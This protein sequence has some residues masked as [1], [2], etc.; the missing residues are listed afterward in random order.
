M[1]LPLPGTK[2][3]LR[4]LRNR[5][6]ERYRELAEMRQELAEVRQ[7]LAKERKKKLLMLAM[8]ALCLIYLVI[9]GTPHC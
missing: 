3:E 6:R 8:A 9:R 1:T 7:Q 5:L 4:E 2:D